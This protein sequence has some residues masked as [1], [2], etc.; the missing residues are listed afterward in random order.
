[1]SL[2]SGPTIVIS[3]SPSGGP[4]V[5]ALTTS[6]TSS[7]K[8]GIASRTSSSMFW[9]SIGVSGSVIKNPDRCDPLP[10]PGPPASCE[11]PSVT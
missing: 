3:R 1:M 2:K 7:P 9:S 4:P 6:D 5:T 11:L 10:A 8:S